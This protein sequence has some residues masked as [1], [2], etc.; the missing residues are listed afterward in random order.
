MTEEIKFWPGSQRKQTFN[1]RVAASDDDDQVLGDVEHRT[2]PVWR[3]RICGEAGRG[4]QRQTYAI[5]LAA[6]IN[7]LDKQHRIGTGN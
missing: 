4:T 1:I 3:C 5:A 2:R 7:H 6:L